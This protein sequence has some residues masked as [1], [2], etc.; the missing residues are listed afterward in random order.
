MELLFRQNTKNK[1]Q[2]YIHRGQMG[3]QTGCLGGPAWEQNLRLC[4]YM[5][6]LKSKI[7]LSEFS[8]D[9]DGSKVQF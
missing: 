3:I 9:R 4:A 8:H 1:N 6:F 5:N 7:E 2:T